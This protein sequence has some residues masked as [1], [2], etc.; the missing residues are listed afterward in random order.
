MFFMSAASFALSRFLASDF[1]LTNYLT[2][3]L[4]VDRISCQIC[5]IVV[6]SLTVSGQ[7]ETTYSI[8]MVSIVG[9]RLCNSCNC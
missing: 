8:K 9:I 2:N 5:R 4:S 7:P 1:L 3:Y 6:A